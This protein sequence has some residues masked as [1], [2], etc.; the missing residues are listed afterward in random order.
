[1]KRQLA[2]ILLLALFASSAQAALLSRLS[3]AAYYD[4]V[5]NI[6]WRADANLADT[7][8]FGVAGIASAGR[9]S[10]DTALPHG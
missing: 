10:W 4:D 5:L 7:N 6:T 9:M 8:R 2:G 3:G 1:M